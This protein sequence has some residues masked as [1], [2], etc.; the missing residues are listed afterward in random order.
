MKLPITCNKN[1]ARGAGNAGSSPLG[2]EGFRLPILTILFA[3]SAYLSPAQALHAYSSQD[4][5]RAKTYFD[6]SWHYGLNSAKHQLYLDSA[7]MI[8]P[9]HAWYWQQKSMPLYKQQKYQLG[10]P[11]LDSAVKYDPRRWL[12]YRAFMKCI[13]EK[14]YRESLADFYAVRAMPGNNSSV[15]DHPYSFYIGLCHLQLNNFD[16]SEYY[17]KGCIDDEVKTHGE[18]WV[19]CNHLYYLGIVY[20]E[21]GN[22]PAAFD[23]FDRAIKLYDKFCDAKYYKAICQLKMDKKKEA[24]ITMDEANTNFKDGFGMNEDNVVY[25]KYPYQVPKGAYAAA[26]EYFHNEADK[27]N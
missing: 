18:K 12:D 6:S 27:T 23:C 13:F 21:K 14:N 17:L 8:I 25:E 15:M 24:A 16:S 4:S 1:F 7:L 11:F 3:L 22:Y 2:A 5:A 10:R 19:H 26:V 20:I 9:T